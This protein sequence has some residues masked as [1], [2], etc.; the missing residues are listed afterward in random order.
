MF[1]VSPVS[2]HMPR[3]AA[4]AVVLA[5]LFIAWLIR[6]EKR[7]E[8]RIELWAILYFAFMVLNA[9]VSVLNGNSGRDALSE[10]VPAGE[11][12]SCFLLTSRV[13]FDAARAAKWAFLI[14][15]AGLTRAV[16]QLI[17]IFSGIPIIPPIYDVEHAFKARETIGNFVYVRPID[18]VVGIFVAIAFIFY[19]C[20]VHRLLAITVMAVCSAVSLLGQTRSEWIASVVCMIPT[21]VMV[22]GAALRRWFTAVA[23]VAAAIAVLTMAVPDFNQFLANRLFKY[24]QEQIEDPRDE[25]AELRILEMGTA[26]TKFSEAPI[27]GHGLG[28]GFGTQVWN[29]SFFEFVQFHNYYLNLLANAGLAGLIALLLMAYKSFRFS[30]ALLRAA[31]VPVT[32]AISIC[33]IATL[34]WWAIFVAFQPIYSTYHVTVLIGLF[35]GM[36]LALQAP[37]AEAQFSDGRS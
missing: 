33:A 37:A 30:T 29:G 27:L 8:A 23:V 13:V 36:A 5:L 6:D 26:A 7:I 10:L 34:I 20:G 21:A 28:S 14:L 32:K 31:T 3:L 2:L 4:L 11:V 12:L 19:I 9:T 18:P 25:L 16:W 24:T 1:V 22:G 15:V 35:F 17:L